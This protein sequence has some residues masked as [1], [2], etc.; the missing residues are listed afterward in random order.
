MLMSIGVN[1]EK[2]INFVAKLEILVAEE[3]VAP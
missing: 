1:S 3:S 2:M